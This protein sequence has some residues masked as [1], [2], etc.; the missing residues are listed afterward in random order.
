MTAW[1][2]ILLGLA[3]AQAAPDSL[4]GEWQVKSVEANGM[5]AP[6][7]NIKGMKLI[8][9]GDTFKYL[10]GEKVVLEGTFKADQKKGTLDAEGKDPQGQVVKTIGIMDLKG[11]TMRVCF[12]KEGEQRPKEFSAKEGSNSSLITYQR[13]KTRDK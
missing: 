1:M 10:M 5:K 8:L 7:D 6:E 9:K 11:D 3:F 4:D 12:V 13:V 2:I